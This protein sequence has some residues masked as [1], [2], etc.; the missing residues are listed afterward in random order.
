MASESV[1]RKFLGNYFLV[2]MHNGAQSGGTDNLESLSPVCLSSFCSSF[3]PI[4]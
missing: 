3:F 2:V 1:V 4:L